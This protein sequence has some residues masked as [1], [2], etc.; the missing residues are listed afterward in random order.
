MKKSRFT[1]NQ[2][3]GIL[4][5]ADTGVAANEIWREHEVSS[6]TSYRRKAKYGGLESARERGRIGGRPPALPAY[7]YRDFITDRTKYLLC[8]VSDINLTKRSSKCRPIVKCGA[9]FFL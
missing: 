3:V 6:A 5:E 2:I 8:A 4:E 1:E 7:S 9:G